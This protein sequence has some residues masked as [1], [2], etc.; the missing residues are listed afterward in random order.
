[1]S[2]TIIPGL[3]RA[4]IS[5]VSSRPTRRP[6]IEV[7][8]R[9]ALPDDVIDVVR[10]RDWRPE[11][12]WS[13]IKSSDQRAFGLVSTGIGARASTAR[14]RASLAHGEA[15]HPIEPINTVDPGRL[16]LLAQQDEQAGC[17]RSAR[18]LASSRSCVRSSVSGGRTCSEPSCDRRQSWCLPLA[19]EGSPQSQRPCGWARSSRFRA[20]IGDVELAHGCF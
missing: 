5:V 7:S 14:R 19:P 18:A 1:M 17:S 8:H 6:E 13:W 12:N 9:P 10:I 2:E 20:G 16:A 15:F 11:A 4:S 3:P